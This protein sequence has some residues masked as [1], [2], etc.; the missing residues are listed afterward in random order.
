VKNENQR[1]GTEHVLYVI[2]EGKLKDEL[3]NLAY[4]LRVEVVFTGNVHPERVS[5]IFNICEKFLLFSD[6]EGYGQVIDEAKLCGCQTIVTAGDGKEEHADIILSRP[7]RRK[8]NK[9][10][11]GY[12]PW[13]RLSDVE[14]DSD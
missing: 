4:N 14:I 8:L 11:T 12:Q 13:E 3:K 1:T 6:D 2:G 7:N 5:E 10:L 9:I